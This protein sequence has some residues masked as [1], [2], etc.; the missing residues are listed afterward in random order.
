MNIL[1]KF[2]T[3]FL[4]TIIEIYNFFSPFFYRG[5]CRFNPTCSQYCR[6]SIIKNGPILGI[7]KSLIRI[8]KCHP[9]G[10]HGFDPVKAKEINKNERTR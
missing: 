8:L 9:F 3:K 5:S 6:Q 1:S 7:Y 4:I 10:K 2:I